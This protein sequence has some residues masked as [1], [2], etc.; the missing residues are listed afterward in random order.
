MCVG[1]RMRRY[2]LVCVRVVV[3]PLLSISPGF[4]M[5]HSPFW[6][7]VRGGKAARPTEGGVQAAPLKRRQRKAAPGQR[8][9]WGKHHNPKEQ[10]AKQHHPREEEGPPLN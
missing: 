9:Q 5:I 1:V 3:C 6:S 4:A 8:A 2:E 10:E 7:G